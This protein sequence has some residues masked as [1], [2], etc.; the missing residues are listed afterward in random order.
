VLLLLAIENQRQFS[1]DRVEIPRPCYYDCDDSVFDVLIMATL[2]ERDR[3]KRRRDAQGGD[4]PPK[5]SKTASVHSVPPPS[6]EYTVLRRIYH[7]VFTLR[8]YLRSRFTSK[9][10]RRIIS[11]LGGQDS[12]L[13]QLLDTVLI[14]TLANGEANPP[15]EGIVGKDEQ[16]KV[17]SRQLAVCPAR[18]AFEPSSYVRMLTFLLVK[19]M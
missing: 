3:K 14:G 7:D 19:A 8:E 6:I 10:W 13:D 17:F 18:A 2:T 4:R 1:T 12:E 9:S 15:K 11:R 5:R 16:I